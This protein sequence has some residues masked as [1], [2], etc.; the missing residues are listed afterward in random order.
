MTLIAIN[1]LRICSCQMDD[2]I[3]LDYPF[4]FAIKLPFETNIYA[5]FSLYDNECIIFVPSHVS[6]SPFIQVSICLDDYN[7]I[8]ELKYV[9]NVIG[10]NQIPAKGGGNYLL[11]IWDYIAKITKIKST[12]VIDMSHLSITVSDE[13]KK[14][15]D[16][17]HEQVSL[18]FLSMMTNDNYQT[19]YEKNGYHFEQNL[20]YRKIF[21][22]LPSD[23]LLLSIKNELTTYYKRIVDFGTYYHLLPTIIEL[24][25]DCHYHSHMKIKEYL[26]KLW[27]I[28]KFHYSVIEKIIFH[29][30]DKAIG[31]YVSVINNDEQFLIKNHC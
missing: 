17:V 13:M 5:T 3:R 7:N 15:E 19:W 23:V 21:F 26:L 27:L 24:Y 11:K 4:D 10:N 16:Q 12:N 1:E 22:N 2:S 29:S 14:F 31:N 6:N 9:R 8:A 28:N 25:V 20:E 18:K 30:N